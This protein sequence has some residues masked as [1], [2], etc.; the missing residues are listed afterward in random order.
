MNADL[1][2]DLERRFA[3]DIERGPAVFSPHDSHNKS[4]NN[5]GGDKMGPDRHGY[6]ATYADVLGR[7]DGPLVLVELGVFL[8]TS[9]AVWDAAL[10]KVDLFGLDLELGRYRAHLPKLQARGAFPDQLPTVAEWDAYRPDVTVLE[11][12][13][14]GRPIDVFVD[15][16]PHTPDAIRTVAEAVRP[17]MADRCVYIVEDQP[18]AAD[19]LRPIWPDA[20][21]WQA[22][23]MAVAC[24]LDPSEG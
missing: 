20:E 14:G 24:R 21:V 13:L 5:L 6:A 2:V 8:G 7:L 16:G 9:L 4:P 1:L 19:L 23:E 17:L 3:P 22:G 18:K 15:D 11:E 10:P 12:L